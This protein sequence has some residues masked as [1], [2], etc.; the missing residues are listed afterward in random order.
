MRLLA[1]TYGTEGDTRPLAMLCHGLIS[2]GH[3]VTLLA[4]GGTLGSAQALDVPHAALEG[5]IHDE[6]VALVSR[7]NGAGA[8]PNRYRRSAQKN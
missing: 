5:D 1:L 8:T 2:A 4:D 6:V 7:G 3:A